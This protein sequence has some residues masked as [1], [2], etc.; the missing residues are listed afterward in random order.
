MQII[1][2]W[3]L[4]SRIAKIRKTD[5]TKCWQEEGIQ[6]HPASQRG[7]H[8]VQ[9]PWRVLSPSLIKLK[10]CPS[11]EQ[12]NTHLHIHSPERKL[13]SPRDLSR[14]MYKSQNQAKMFL[15]RC[16]FLVIKLPYFI[17]HPQI[18]KHMYS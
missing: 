5:N 6:N 10:T 11:Y 13:I 16:T 12:A 2:T 3:M 18:T 4:C 14:T 17:P 1:A 7:V 8:P 15:S 9:T